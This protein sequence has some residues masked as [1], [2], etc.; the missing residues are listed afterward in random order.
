MRS[1]ALSIRPETPADEA[2]VRTV[3]ERAFGRPVEARLVDALRAA[4]PDRLSL[5]AVTPAGEVV[6]HV[7]FTPVTIGPG[8]PAAA[9]AHGTAVPPGMGLGPLAVLPELQR[10]GIGSALMERS[11]LDLRAAGCPFVAV[12]GHPEY[13]PR[14]GFV[15]ASGLGLRSQW[16]AVPDEAWMALVLDPAAP[17]AGGVVRFHPEFDAAAQDAPAVQTPATTE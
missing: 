1:P 17:P 11:L 6:G 12:V 8:G 4:C 7:L 3:E 10:Q 9:G 2:G 13:Y 14:F 16:D 5:V 15:L